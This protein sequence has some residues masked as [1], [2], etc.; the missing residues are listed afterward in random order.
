MSETKV[1]VSVDYEK[2]KELESFYDAHKN[3]MIYINESCRSM[4]IP[5]K[6]NN[7]KN[8]VKRV[9]RIIDGHESYKEELE[10]EYS[11]RER[12]KSFVWEKKI[13]DFHDKIFNLEREIWRLKEKRN[14]FGF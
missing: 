1:T 7:I 11:D 3:E 6:F 12:Q 5:S 14:W 8:I 4:Y 13:S 10:R 2:Y 9:S